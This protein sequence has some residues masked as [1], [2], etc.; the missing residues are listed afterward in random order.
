[1]LPQS[2]LCEIKLRGHCNAPRQSKWHI[3]W[4]SNAFIASAAEQQQPKISDYQTTSACRDWGLILR[5]QW[6]NQDASTYKRCTFNYYALLQPQSTLKHS[7]LPPHTHTS[8]TQSAYLRGTGLK[9]TRGAN[10]TQVSLTRE[11]Q[12]HGIQVKLVKIIKLN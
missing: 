2:W 4:L 8:H 1:M 6:Q 9:Y 7:L 11:G 12:L 3:N 5:E 10:E